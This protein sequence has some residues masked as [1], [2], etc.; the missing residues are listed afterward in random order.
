MQLIPDEVRRR[1]EGAGTP[2]SGPGPAPTAGAPAN[3]I[4]RRWRR[5]S[6]R[7][8][9]RSAADGSSSY[10][11]ITRLGFRHYFPQDTRALSPLF[12]LLII[13]S[14]K[15]LSF[16]AASQRPGPPIT[17]PTSSSWAHHYGRSTY[18]RNREVQVFGI[19]VVAV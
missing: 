10:T 2:P 11:S 9:L 15:Y 16:A 7:E 8:M 14:A 5:R 18:N 1:C 3:T 6:Q 4:P 17:P 13:I 12:S 19:H